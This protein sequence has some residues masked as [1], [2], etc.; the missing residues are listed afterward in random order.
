[1]KC[2]HCLRGASQ[3]KSIPN[4][5]VHKIFNLID[6]VFSLTVTGGEVTLDMDALEYLLQCIRYDPCEVGSFYLVTNGKSIPVEKLAQWVQQM[7]S[8]CTDNELSGVGFSF[9]RYHTQTLTQAQVEKRN[10]NFHD[11]QEILTYDYGVCG[12]N[13]E[14]IVT[15]H[16]QDKYPLRLIR[17]GRAKHFGSKDIKKEELRE[18]KRNRGEISF[19]ESELY[20]SCNGLLVAG[21]DWSY[22]TIDNRKDIRIAHIDDIHCQ[23]DL[24]KA[25]RRYNRNLRRVKKLVMFNSARIKKEQNN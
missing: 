13:G 23:D 15:K 16:T 25:I 18:E 12:A 11:F 9:D 7:D 17:E 3:R 20:L 19:I 1:M 2:P 14:G 8:V 24:I 10:N 22:N 6:Y 21:C 4:E 5:Y